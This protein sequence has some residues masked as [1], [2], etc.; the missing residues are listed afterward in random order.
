MKHARVRFH[1]QMNPTKK[2]A[3]C[4]QSQHRNLT[5]AWTPYVHPLRHT[6]ACMNQSLVSSRISYIDLE[7]PSMV[8][9]S[10]MRSLWERYLWDPIQSSLKVWKRLRERGLG[11]SHC[12]APRD[13][14]TAKA[15]LEDPWEG[16][17][18]QAKT[19]F[20]HFEDIRS[21][22]LALEIHFPNRKGNGKW[23]KISTCKE[24]MF[25]FYANGRVM[26]PW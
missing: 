8:S 10:S 9:S 18:A 12:W 15:L 11:Y 13:A 7:K 24:W 19:I 26:F 14:G 4:S 22:I 2:L 23:D 5:S 25:H 21:N 3:D 17:A 1:D 20:S 6:V 16:D